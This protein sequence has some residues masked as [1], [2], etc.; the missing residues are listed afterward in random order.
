MVERCGATT[1]LVVVVAAA[2]AAALVVEVAAGSWWAAVE[3]AE[4]EDDR[5]SPWQPLAE[6]ADVTNH[7]SSGAALS[8][9]T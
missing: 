6:R 9:K 7:L 8:P 4:V 5:P 1:A 3:E 2:A